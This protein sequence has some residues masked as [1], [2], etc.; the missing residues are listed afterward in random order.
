LPNS[1]LNWKYDLIA[2]HRK[3]IFGHSNH[4]GLNLEKDRARFLDLSQ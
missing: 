4:C 3:K 1:L 2:R